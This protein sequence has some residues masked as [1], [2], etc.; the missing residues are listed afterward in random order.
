MMTLTAP[1]MAFRKE[2]RLFTMCVLSVMEEHY[3]CSL[4][5]H[6]GT[7][8]A[9]TYN[10]LFFIYSLGEGLLHLSGRHW[11]LNRRLCAKVRGFLVSRQELG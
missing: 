7:L 8:D 1:K 9:F 11:G 3:H 2:F 5:I 4:R 6:R 10:S